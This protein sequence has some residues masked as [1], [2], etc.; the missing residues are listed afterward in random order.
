MAKSAKLVYWAHGLKLAQQWRRRLGM[1]PEAEWD[2][3]RQSLAPLP[4][5]DGVYLAHENCPQTFTKR[6][7]DHPSMLA[8]LGVLPAAAMVVTLPG[9]QSAA[10][11]SLWVR[12]ILFTPDFLIAFPR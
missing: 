7:R 3:V 10:I 11:P 12:G 5:K 8:G 1:A 9:G 2:R 4:V 6:N